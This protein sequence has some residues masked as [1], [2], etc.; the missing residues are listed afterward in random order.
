LVGQVKLLQGL[1]GET[2][3]TSEELLALGMEELAKMEQEYQRC[4]RERS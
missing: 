3:G 2:P 1:S 4:L